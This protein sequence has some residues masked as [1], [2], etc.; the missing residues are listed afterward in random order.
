[1]PEAELGSKAIA[2]ACCPQQQESGAWHA[3]QEEQANASKDENKQHMR[4]DTDLKRSIRAVCRQLESH[5]VCPLTHM[6]GKQQV[7]QAGGKGAETGKNLLRWSRWDKIR[8]WTGAEGLITDDDT[9]NLHKLL[10]SRVTEG[11][12]ELREK[13]NVVYTPWTVTLRE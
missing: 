2:V 3:L 4:W 1:M 13:Y 8:D 5:A 12:Q 10:R 6:D 9:L 11:K 7:G